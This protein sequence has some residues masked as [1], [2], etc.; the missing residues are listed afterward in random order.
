MKDFQ[1]CSS[2]LKRLSFGKPRHLVIYLARLKVNFS[3]FD[4]RHW[5]GL[6]T[7]YGHPISWKAIAVLTSVEEL[8]T[9]EIFIYANNKFVDPYKGMDANSLAGELCF[10]SKRSILEKYILLTDWRKIQSLLMG[11][12]RAYLFSWTLLSLVIGDE[13]RLYKVNVSLKRV[14]G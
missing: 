12:V 4:I 5:T 1:T 8:M 3:W 13:W 10:C 14:N 9:S 11:I 2:E 7:K 6:T